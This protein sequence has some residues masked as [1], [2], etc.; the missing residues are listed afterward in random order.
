MASDVFR[1]SLFPR[2]ILNLKNY[3][4]LERKLEIYKYVKAHNQLKL[5]I[6]NYGSIAVSEIM[7]NSKLK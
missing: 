3:D 7:L 6:I 2:L 1:K 4:E 5:K